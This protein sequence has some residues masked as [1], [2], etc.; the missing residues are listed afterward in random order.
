M[1]IYIRV[2]ILQLCP[3]LIFLI[4]PIACFAQLGRLANQLDSTF[5][6]NDTTAAKR[7]LA[8]SLQNNYFLL[9]S[10]RGRNR[11]DSAEIQIQDSGNLVVRFR[12]VLPYLHIGE[13][14][15]RDPKYLFVF[16]P[17]GGTSDRG[18][19]KPSDYSSSH[20]AYLTWRD[21]IFNE[22]SLQLPAPP[23]TLEV[24]IK[25]TSTLYVKIPPKRFTNYRVI[26]SASIAAGSLIWFAFE[27]HSANMK[28]DEYDMAQTASE[29]VRLRAE[30]E[31]IRK[32]RDIAGTI[33][34][35]SGAFTALFYAISD[36]G[37]E[38]T[39]TN[40]NGPWSLNEKLHLKV[41]PHLTM[42]ELR[43]AMHLKF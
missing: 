29:T 31:T 11:P 13:N 16:V 39:S 27:W 6:R 7:L 3:L 10:S 8:K 34:L 5:T 43:I 21:G 42:N 37:S 1:Y 36:P 33:A 2:S 24:P 17:L 22:E 32:R 28:F 14:K 18:S 40:R 38:E 9:L 41:K 15:F 25:T 20:L 19:Y 30:V 23:D 35:V 12:T 26:S 4:L